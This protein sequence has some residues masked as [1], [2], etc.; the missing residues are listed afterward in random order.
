MYISQQLRLGKYLGVNIIL[1]GM[2]MM[3]HVFPTNFGGFFA[4]RLVLGE[5]SHITR[6]RVVS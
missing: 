3:L 5:L 1:W 2:V 6:V 4:I